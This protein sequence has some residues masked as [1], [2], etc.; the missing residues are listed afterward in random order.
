MRTPRLFV[1]VVVVVVPIRDWKTKHQGG[2]RL[3]VSIKRGVCLKLTVSMDIPLNE[4]NSTVGDLIPKIRQRPRLWKQVEPSETWRDIPEVSI[5][6]ETGST[7]ASVSGS[8]ASLLPGASGIAGG[9]ILSSAGAYIPG[10]ALIAG[11]ILYGGY[12]GLKSLQAPGH[13]YL[14]PGTDLE[15]AKNPVD[16]DDQ[17]AKEHD[18]AYSKIKTAKDVIKADSTAI[19]AFE[20]DFAATGNLHSKVSSTIL[21]AKQAVEHY[22][23]PIYPQV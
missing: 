2:K 22:I 7:T 23:G 8:T 21:G 9:S 5:D 18:I 16:S 11:G 1:V 4:F 13:E 6:I 19:G 15:A 17:I 20:D 12:H 14:G 10:G 3:C